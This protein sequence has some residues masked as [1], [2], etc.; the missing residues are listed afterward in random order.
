MSETYRFVNIRGVFGNYIPSAEADRLLGNGVVT[1][2]DPIVYVRGSMRCPDDHCDAF[3][4]VCYRPIGFVGPD[5]CPLCGQMVTEWNPDR[6][7]HD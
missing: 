5:E 3:F 1:S 6:E 4:A 2:D 7:H